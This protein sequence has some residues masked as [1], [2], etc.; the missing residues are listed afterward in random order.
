LQH[1]D[2]LAVDAND[3]IY[4][5]NVGNPLILVYD[6]QGHFVRDIGRI[7]D[8]FIFEAPTGIAIDA[9]RARLYV[10]D[11]P[12]NELL[13]LDLDGRVINRLGGNRSHV[14]GVQFDTPTEIA[15]RGNTIAVLDTYGSRVQVF[16]TECKPVSSFN[17]RRVSGTPRVNEI[18]LGLDSLGNI[19][20]T[21]QGA[22]GIKIY[23]RRGELIGAVADPIRNVPDSS[24]SGLWIDSADRMYVTDSDAG[25]VHVFN[26]AAKA[27]G[28]TSATD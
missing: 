28:S 17:L 19:Y 26:A 20:L 23:S 11:S 8:E 4:V 1:P 12:M 7:E 27:A 9:H 13:I 2:G 18:G 24:P 10:L 16:D 5:T 25:R 14:A 21:R 22:S 3:N 15:V 6:A